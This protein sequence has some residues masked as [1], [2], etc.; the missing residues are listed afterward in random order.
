VS[1]EPQFELTRQVDLSTFEIRAADAA[2]GGPEFSGWA[3]RTGVVDAY[4]TTFQAGCWSA[5]GLDSD[6]YA[7]C[8]F[9]NPMHPV[10]VLEAS[11]REE[12]L[13]IQGEWD[14]TPEG[15][16]ARIRGQE[17]GSARQLSVGCR[18]ILYAEDDRNLI[19]AA[20]LVEVSQITA[21]MAAVPGAGI[22]SARNTSG[23][24]TDPIRLARAR[25]LLT[26]LRS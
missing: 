1:D 25:L 16:T 20:Q 17:R 7:M 5:G 18:G 24:A 11:E 3:C 19:I 23:A 13:W 2:G 4:G 10:G 22:T 8:W 26:P 21:R 14:D 9:H 12:G 15:R 6:L